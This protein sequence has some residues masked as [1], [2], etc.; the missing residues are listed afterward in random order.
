[1]CGRFAQRSPA[2]KITKKFKVE[3]MPPLVEHYNVAPAQAVLAIRDASGVR[4][5]AFLKWG[6]VPRWAKDPGMAAFLSAPSAHPRAE[7]IIVLTNRNDFTPHPPSDA[8][9]FALFERLVQFA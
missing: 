8:G 2:K 5:A 9:V 6:L 3:E 4:E 7:N 1:M